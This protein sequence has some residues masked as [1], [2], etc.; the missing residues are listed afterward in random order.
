[1]PIG[2]PTEASYLVVNDIVLATPA[3]FIRSLAPLHEDA[4]LVGRSRRLPRGRTR[5]YR[6]WRTETT[7]TFAL[8]IRGFKDHTGAT[9]ADPLEGL[10]INSAF[11]RANLGIA[12]PTGDG[13]VPAVW[14]QFSGAELEA[15]VYP[16]LKGA[17]LL[18]AFDLLTTLD[19]V[20][21]SPGRFT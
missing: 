5:N 19:L 9:H 11:L 18:S 1:M 2:I 20:V 13:T 15:D 3:W 7:Y 17:T 8:R 4:T 10:E 14:H 16:D 12:S 21:P 6:R